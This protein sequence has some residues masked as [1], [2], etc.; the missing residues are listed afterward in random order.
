MFDIG[1]PELVVIAVVALVV[2]GPKDLPFA[3]R[4]IGR[5]VAKARTMA[6]EFQ[7]H[8]DDMVREA[9][10]D[11][12]RKKATELKDGVDIKKHVQNAIDPSGTIRD[13]LTPPSIMAQPVDAFAALPETKPTDPAPAGAAPADP[14]AAPVPVAGPTVYDPASGAM[15]PAEPA[16]ATPAPVAAEAK[17]AGDAKV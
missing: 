14:V 8:V 11:E 5:F 10:L 9:E 17:P 13:A 16:P 1:W 6:R 12:L 4:T 7:T 3:L 15:A 2:I